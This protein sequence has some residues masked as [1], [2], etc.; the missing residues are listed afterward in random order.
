M[1]GTELN[2][3]RKLIEDRENELRNAWKQ[4]FNGCSHQHIEARPLASQ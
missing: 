3:V 2:L 1:A 4:H